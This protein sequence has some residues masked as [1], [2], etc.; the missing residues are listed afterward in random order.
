M[1][2][3]SVSTNQNAKLALEKSKKLLDITRKIL[4]NISSDILSYEVDTEKV[5]KENSLLAT[6]EFISNEQ[7]KA[8]EFED[9]V[10]AWIDIDT[11]LM[12][13]VKTKE[14]I[15]HQYVWNKESIKNSLQA[16]ALTDSVTDAFLYA[17]KLNAQNFGGFNDWRVPTR[18]ELKTLLT[19]KKNNNYYIKL[20]LSCNTL[21]NGYWSSTTYKNFKHYAWFVYFN[22]GNEYHYSKYYNYYVRCVRAG[23]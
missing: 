14:N 8:I 19:K 11:G 18:E 4:V 9:K 23:C 21:S 3:Q 15:K 1:K 7:N 5:K 16:E 17:E 20:A 2:N 6:K 12:W 10:E 22:L 13:E